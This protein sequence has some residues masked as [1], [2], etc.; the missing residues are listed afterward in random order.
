MMVIPCSDQ[1]QLSPLHTEYLGMESPEISVKNEKM[2]LKSAKIAQ[3]KGKNIQ[4]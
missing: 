1:V 4:V 2:C 3:K